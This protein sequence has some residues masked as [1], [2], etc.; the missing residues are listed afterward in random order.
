VNNLREQGGDWERAAF[1]ESFGFAASAGVGVLGIKAAAAIFLTMTPLGWAAI[2]VTTAGL[3][4]LA[5]DAG[6]E[7]GD[8]LYDR[9]KRLMDH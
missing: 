4:L 1:V 5:N 8:R 2:I 7:V 3:S 6:K 9:V